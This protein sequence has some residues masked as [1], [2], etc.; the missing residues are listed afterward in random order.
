M[1]LQPVCGW[2][3]RQLSASRCTVLIGVSLEG[4]KEGYGLR[5]KTLLVVE[6]A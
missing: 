6:L 5:K 1:F 2:P 3:C 4:L